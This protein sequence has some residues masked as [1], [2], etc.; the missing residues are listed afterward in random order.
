MVSIIPNNWIE[1]NV[2][3]SRDVTYPNFVHALDFN[4][5]GDILDKP[6]E[7]LMLDRTITK[8]NS[9][10]SI[11]D[12]QNYARYWHGYLIILR[13]LLVFTDI[14]GI[15]WINMFVFYI[16]L[17]TL[18]YYL[19]TRT[20]PSYSLFLLI[21][22]IPAHFYI[23]PCCMQYIGVFLISFIASIITLKKDQLDFG[24]LMFIVGCLTSFFDFLTAPLITLILPLSIYMLLLDRRLTIKEQISHILLFSAIWSAGYVLFWASKWVIGS[25][26]LQRNILAEA[27]DR[28]S[29]RAGTYNLSRAMSVIGTIGVYFGSNMKLLGISI[30]AEFTGIAILSIKK[31]FSFCW[32][33]IIQGIPLLWYFL[34]ANHSLMHD[35]MTYRNVIVISFLGLILLKNAWDCILS[36]DNSPFKK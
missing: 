17:G 12:A 15:Y 30:L 28:I 5:L 29:L 1:S 10:I 14:K 18:L 3:I 11:I 16:L 6:T 32:K 19:A 2:L 20:K 9:F 31:E 7:S 26:I 8:G 35:Y 24:L 34:T 4:K 33:L 13:P 36:K 27:N 23:I 25:L 22:M 21:S